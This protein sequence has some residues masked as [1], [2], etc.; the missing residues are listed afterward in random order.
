MSRRFNY[1]LAFVLILV[2]IGFLL[3][4]PLQNYLVQRQSN[5]YLTVSA[6]EIDTNQQAN[7]S[8]DFLEVEEVSILD[9][10]RAQNAEIDAPIIGNIIVPDVD[11][12]LPILKGVSD[13]NLLI[14]AGTLKEEQEMGVGNYA[15]AS[16]NMRNPNL[17]FSP[18]HRSEIGMS[19][20]IT[21]MEYVYEYVIHTHD[22]IEPT[23][24]E[25]IADQ[26]E[27]MLT[28]ITCNY[29][30]ERRLLVQA[31]F[32]EKVPIEDQEIF[33]ETD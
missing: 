15:L 27:P 18:L 17:L 7:T 23:Q 4:T 24:V 19:V 13:S 1:T 5:H 8:F 9:I 12:H 16:H 6:T 33:I 3:I 10:L 31:E 26:S 30:G 32:I 11:L 25:V 28:L 21:D 14:G 22:I 20:Y 2:G 29:N